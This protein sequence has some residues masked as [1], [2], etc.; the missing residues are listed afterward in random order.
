MKQNK[1]QQQKQEINSREQKANKISSKNTVS[2]NIAS[3][4]PPSG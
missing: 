1:Q 2:V 3:S 4:A